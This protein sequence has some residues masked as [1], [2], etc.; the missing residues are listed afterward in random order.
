MPYIILEQSKLFLGETENDEKIHLNQGDTL[1][2]TTDETHIAT[3]QNMTIAVKN[4]AGEAFKSNLVG[5]NVFFDMGSICAVVKRMHG[6]DMFECEV[7]NE[8]W[9]YENQTIVF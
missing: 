3:Q 7:Q 2:V 5:K 8:G 4:R 1:K 6:R 9:I